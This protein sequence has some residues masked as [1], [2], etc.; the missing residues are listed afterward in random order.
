MTDFFLTDL[1]RLKLLRVETQNGTLTQTVNM[2][3][4]QEVRMEELSLITTGNHTFPLTI[5]TH[6]A[7]SHEVCL[8][9]PQHDHPFTLIKPLLICIE[10]LGSV[11]LFQKRQSLFLAKYKIS[12][13]FSVL[14]K[15]IISM[16]ILC[17]S[18]KQIEN[19]EGSYFTC[20]IDLES[21]Y[22]LQN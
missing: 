11:I 2:A 13:T 7:K 21:K 15:C 4:L 12:R 10:P 9:N 3:D 8:C 5:I 19:M 22:L 18:K 20:S 14:V 17:F 1:P 16:S 6:N